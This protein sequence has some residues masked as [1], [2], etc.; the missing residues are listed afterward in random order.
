[1]RVR[2]DSQSWV[3]NIDNDGQFASIPPGLDEMCRI[4]SHVHQQHHYLLG[5]V[6]V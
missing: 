4:I 5:R 1:M 2:L 6:E 3:L